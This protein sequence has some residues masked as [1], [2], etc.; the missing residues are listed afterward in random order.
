[1]R[2]LRI[3]K[4]FLV[5]LLI[6]AVAGL[7]GNF[8]NIYQYDFSS[9]VFYQNESNLG[10]TK[11]WLFFSNDIGFYIGLLF[12]FVGIQKLIKEKKFT[13]QSKSLFALSGIILFSLALF[14]SLL[15]IVDYQFHDKHF[16]IQSLSFNFL[17]IILS[18]LLFAVSDIIKLGQITQEENELTI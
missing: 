8:V 5:V 9:K 16:M 1:M 6:L 13:S 14:Q 17:Q 15:Y 2:K 10:E 3:L 7:I 18:L 12:L 11:F 4:W